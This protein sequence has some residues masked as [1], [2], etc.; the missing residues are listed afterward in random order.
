M[1]EEKPASKKDFK[2][3]ISDFASTQAVAAEKRRK[4]DQIKYNKDQAR[5][6]AIAKELEKA[7]ATKTLELEQDLRRSLEDQKAKSKA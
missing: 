6:V 7:N 5:L 4:D 1:A 3:V 2:D